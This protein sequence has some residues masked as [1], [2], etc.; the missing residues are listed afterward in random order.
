MAIRIDPENSETRALF[1]MV[2]FGGQPICRS[3]QVVGNAAPEVAAIA[4]RK[5]V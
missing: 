1:E 2:N 5:I 4:G 3:I